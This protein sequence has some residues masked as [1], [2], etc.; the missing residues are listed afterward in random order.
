[1]D[2]IF[3]RPVTRR[4]QSGAKIGGKMPTPWDSGSALSSYNS[5]LGAVQDL[6]SFGSK[7]CDNTGAFIDEIAIANNIAKCTK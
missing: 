1:M 5:A 4:R 2:D 3:G 7:Y 6:V